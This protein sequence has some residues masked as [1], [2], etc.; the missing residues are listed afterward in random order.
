MSSIVN[1]PYSV[2]GLKQIREWHYGVNWPA[3]YIIYNNNTAYVGET[4]DAVRRTEQHLQEG[5]FQKFTEICLI[6]SKTYNKS[7]I[8][9]L[10]SFLIKY[11]S[12][13]ESKKLINGNAGVVDHDYFYREAYEDDFREIWKELMSLHIVSKSLE[14]IENSELFKYSPYKSLNEE[15]Q[16]AAYQILKRLGE[17]N[18]A[19][20]QTIIEVCGGAGTGKTILAVYLIKL[21][22]DISNNR[23]SLEYIDDAENAEAVRR[24]IKK[25]SGINDIGFVV[26]MKEL[27]SVMQRIFDSIDGLSKEMVLRPNEVVKHG[28]YDVLFVDE[29]HRLY[30][31]CN[32][33]SPKAYSE[34][35]AINQ[36]LMGDSF[37]KSVN[38]YTEL[39][40]IIKQS[41][42]QILFYDERQRIRSCDIDA[43]R[44]N[45]I[46]R[47]HIFKYVELFS[48]MRCKGGNGYYD[49]IKKILEGTKLNAKSY[50]LIQNYEVRI[51]DHIEDLFEIINKKEQSDG[52]CRVVCG[53]GWGAK[54]DIIIENRVYKWAQGRDYAYKPDTVLSIHKSQGFDLNYAGV[55]F[56]KEIFYDQSLG[57]VMINK[58]ELKDPMTK[59]DGDDI[60]RQ[61]VLNM[62]LTLMTRGIKGTF[63]YAVDD[64]MRNYLKEFLDS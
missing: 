19:S 1:Y 8:L 13:E 26:P 53:P 58:K 29:A 21:L 36:S 2:A 62:Y 16:R 14:E 43:E 5:E 31:R 11:M 30:R 40:W 39:D 9:D 49:Y 33:S 64:S 50:M 41:R 42:Y 32:L 18:K 57:R 47:P 35:D 37:T 45:N 48:Q 24:L 22:V 63:V 23:K 56:G 15:Q 6:S 52:L 61:N 46:C 7:V 59:S 27:Y 4:L 12:A 28:M 54:E 51:I 34:F 60:M 25:L 20:Q 38:D 17:M 44:Y 55:I 3:V 10:E